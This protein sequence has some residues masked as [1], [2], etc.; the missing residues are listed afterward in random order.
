MI[1]TSEL[2]LIIFKKNLSQSSVA[3]SIGITPKT[4]YA[5]MSK[6]VFNSDEIEKMISLLDIK[7][8]IEVFFANK[9]T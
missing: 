6:G 9:V 1:D 7:N 4:F 8:P 2:K 5:K 3:K